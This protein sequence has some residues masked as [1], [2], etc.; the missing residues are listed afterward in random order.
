MGTWK[1]SYSRNYLGTACGQRPLVSSTY[2]LLVGGPISSIWWQNKHS[3]KLMTLAWWPGVFM[4]G[5]NWLEMTVV[6]PR[7][8]LRS[9]WSA[10]SHNVPV[11]VAYLISL[12]VPFL[13]GLFFFLC[14]FSRKRTSAWSIHAERLTELNSTKQERI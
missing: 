10:N 7:K 12:E 5:S 11:E 13:G 14:G 8:A 4:T 6:F 2:Q 9:T 3:Q 1:C